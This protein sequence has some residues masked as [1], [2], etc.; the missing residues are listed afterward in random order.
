ME[1]DVKIKINNWDKYQ[2][3]KDIKKHWW[4]KLSNQLWIDPDFFHFNP[5]ELLTWI[6][7]L[8]MASEK[9]KSEF[10]F[11]SEMIMRLRSIDQDDIF[12]A[13]EKLQQLKIV[14]AI[15]TR[16]VRNPYSR[17]EKRREEER[18]LKKNPSLI[19]SKK[20]AGDKVEGTRRGTVSFE[21]KF[22]LEKLYSDF[23]RKKG[24]KRGMVTLARLC[25]SQKKYDAISKAIDN[26][27][28]Y[29]ED[30]DVSYIKYFSTFMNEW[31]DWLEPPEETNKISIDEIIARRGRNA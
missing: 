19:D 27:A 9:Q 31:E 11:C 12:S 22:D 30:K 15:C 21:P 5:S 4:F 17:E 14:T 6:C 29:C 24:K 25:T 18:I 20:P 26:Y 28:K 16:S 13:I 8:S 2:G 1:H 23:P 7:I 10:S 3:R